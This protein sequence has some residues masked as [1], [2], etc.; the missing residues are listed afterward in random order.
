MILLFF[1]N[2]VNIRAFGRLFMGMKTLEWFFLRFTTK[3]AEPSGEWLRTVKRGWE[4][5]FLHFVMKVNKFE[6]VVYRRKK[7]ERMGIRVKKK[8]APVGG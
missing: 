8:L 6:R 4:G 5:F 3:A 2:L 7:A 1:N